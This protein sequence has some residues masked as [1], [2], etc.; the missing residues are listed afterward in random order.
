MQVN[1]HSGSSNCKLSR[2]L[3][4]GM[5]FPYGLFS[6][7]RHVR[8]QNDCFSWSERNER[9]VRQLNRQSFSVAQDSFAFT[10]LNECGH[11]RPQPPPN[12]V[13]DQISMRPQCRF[14]AFTPVLR[15]VHLW[16][17]HQRRVLIPGVNGV[18][19]CECVNEYLVLLH[20]LARLM[21]LQ[22]FG[23]LWMSYITIV[24]SKAS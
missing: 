19:M 16:L 1:M 14:S 18:W 17:D 2:L 10:L 9:R 4:A 3:A 21:C 5:N 8:L 24:R 23:H 22:C 13:C 6:V 7:R 15:T 12:V 11:M 20:V